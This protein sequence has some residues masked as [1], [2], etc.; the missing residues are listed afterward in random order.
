MSNMKPVAMDDGEILGTLTEAVLAFVVNGLGFM[1][2]EKIRDLETACAAG[3]AKLSVT[4]E[5]DPVTASCALVPNDR[6]HAAH[7]LFRAEFAPKER[8]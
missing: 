4:I 5:L 3:R 6:S 8:H 1:P 2:A 7:E